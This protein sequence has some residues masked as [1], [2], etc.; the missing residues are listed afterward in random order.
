MTPPDLEPKVRKEYIHTKK[1]ATEQTMQSLSPRTCLKQNVK[2]PN[3]HPNSETRLKREV[4]I[5]DRSR[6][7]T[8]QETISLVM[9]DAFNG[10]S[11]A[12]SLQKMPNKSDWGGQDTVP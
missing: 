6:S 9:G 5:K 8:G 10:E 4:P 3:R 1:W 7:D 2:A 12:N 11:E